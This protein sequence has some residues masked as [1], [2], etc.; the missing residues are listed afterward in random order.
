MHMRPRGS[1]S[2]GVY[3]GKRIDKSNAGALARSMETRP[4]MEQAVIVSRRSGQY[5]R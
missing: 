4:E 3:H 1:V 2:R 5:F